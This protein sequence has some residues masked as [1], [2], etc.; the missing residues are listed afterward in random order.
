MPDAPTDRR[1]DAQAKRALFAS[2]PV[3]PF[4]LVLVGLLACGRDSKVPQ[5]LLDAGVTPAPDVITNAAAVVFWLRD[6]DTLQADSAVVAVQDLTSMS[7]DLVD[8][9]SDTDVAVY[10]TT[11]SRIYVRAPHAPRRVVTLN[12]LDVPW[13]VVFVEPGYAEQIVTGPVSPADFRDMVYDYFGL[14]DEKP[15]GPIALNDR[16]I[17]RFSDWVERVGSGS[18]TQ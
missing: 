6:V 4:V 7:E 5:Q 18:Y 15:S 12:G 10:F 9:L 3:R 11:R 17:E 13:G 16:V 2:S 1:N 14:E 8:L